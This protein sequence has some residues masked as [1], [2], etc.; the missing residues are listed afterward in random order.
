MAISKSSKKI[1]KQKGIARA[2]IFSGRPDPSW[3]VTNT[4]LKQLE[5]IWNSLEVTE[6]IPSS[7]T[8]G[9]RGCLL[10]DNINREW[11]V[12]KDF[13]RLSINGV[14]ETRLDRHTKFEKLLLSSAPVGLLP[15]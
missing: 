13:I 4:L 1:K 3:P 8:L 14:S 7:P 2:I 10:K 15:F 6:K 9:Y 12:Y 11:F 5:N